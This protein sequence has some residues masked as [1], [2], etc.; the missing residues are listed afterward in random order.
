MTAQKPGIL[1]V[2]VRMVAGAEVAAD[3]TALDCKRAFGRPGV[4]VAFLLAAHDVFGVLLGRPRC[5]VIGLV[6]VANDSRWSVL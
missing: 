4:Y 1:P 5:S 6:V 2:L 3:F